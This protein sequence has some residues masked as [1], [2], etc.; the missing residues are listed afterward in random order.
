[1]FHWPRVLLPP[2]PPWAR[3]TVRGLLEEEGALGETSEQLQSGWGALKN[4]L[5]GQLLAVGNAGGG[6]IGVAGVP[7]GRV[8]GGASGGGGDGEGEGGS[9]SLQAKPWVESGEGEVWFGLVCPAVSGRR[10]ASPSRSLLR[11][12]GRS[13]SRRRHRAGWCTEG[14]GGG[15]L[16]G[17]LLLR[18]VLRWAEDLCRRRGRELQL[19]HDGVRTASEEVERGGGG[20]GEGGGGAVRFGFGG[21]SQAH[22]TPGGGHG[23][24]PQRRCTPDG[25]AMR[26]QCLAIKGVWAGGTAR[27]P[28]AP[29]HPPFTPT[30]RTPLPSTPAVAT[31]Q[32]VPCSQSTGRALYLGGGWHKAAV[33]DCVP[34]AAPIGLSP[35][36]I[37]TLCG[38]ER[39]LV[40]STEPLD[41]LSCLT[42]PGVGRPGDG[43]LPVPLTRWGGGS[44]GRSLRLWLSAALIHHWG[45]APLFTGWTAARNNP[46]VLRRIHPPS[47]QPILSDG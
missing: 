41:D 26:P 1:M 33:S 4:R 39:V 34:L 11:A 37:L 32:R 29:P 12:Q 15:G 35:L 44:R 42:T 31:G 23:G 43:L 18:W 20:G 30:G 22:R 21:P 6:G 14:G 46:K 8:E 17:G 10:V 28:L 24:R 40:V 38:P 13:S 25:R 3:G 27:L 36:L 45:L 9:P 16:A 5:G 7:S 19:D 47:P 2:G